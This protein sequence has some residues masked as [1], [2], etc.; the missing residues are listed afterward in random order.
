[1]SFQLALSGSVDYDIGEFMSRCRQQPLPF[2]THGGKRAGA[3]RPPRGPRSS[4]RHQ[5][6]PRL[7][8]RHPVHVTLRTSP[9]VGRL[10]R[11]QVYQAVRWALAITLRRD[12]FRIC[13][14]SI[15]GNHIHLIVEA[16]DERA[17]ARGMQG[18]Q[19]S[20]AK[21]INARLGRGRGTVFPDRYHAEI[22][23][24]PRQVRNALAYVVN[25]WRRHGE[26]RGL[27]HAIDPYSSAVGFNGWRDHH[28]LMRLR[29]GDELLPV[30]FPTVWLLTTGWRRHGLIATRERPGPS[31]MPAAPPGSAARGTAPGR[32]RSRRPCPAARTFPAS[33][34]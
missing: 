9:E 22:L 29:P 25:N 6:R 4:E 17:L 15:Q 3:G 26:D 20:C 5:R 32:T 2:R 30:A 21:Q 14:V 31:A 8:A 12:D 28:R 16:R 13:H 34:A 24:T 11:R 33:R 7:A 19:I 1:M 27:A 23:T 10:R 18:F